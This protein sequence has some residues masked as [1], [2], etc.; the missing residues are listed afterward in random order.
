MMMRL[1]PCGIG[2]IGVNKGELTVRKYLVLIAILVFAFS[3]TACG[4]DDNAQKA[5][6][7]IKKAFSAKAA[8]TFWEKT[9]GISESDVEPDWDWAVYEDNMKTYGD[10]PGTSGGHGSICFEK[11]D[12]SEIS[13]KEYHAW[14][15]K[16]FDATAKAS[17]DGYNIIGWEFVIKQEDPLAKVSFKDAMGLNGNNAVGTQGWGFIK[18][19]KNMIVYVSENY[20]TREKSTTGRD[21]YHY[22]VTVD[23]SYGLDESRSGITKN[24]EKSF[25]DQE[26]KPNADDNND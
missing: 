20:D 13:E 25:D 3:F 26:F 9:V 10:D 16:V 4:A 21:F 7:D 23:I 22:G 17:D 12:R 2:V 1:C 5:E 8:S 11:K 19:K 15:Q 24:M 18:N 6:K 14:A